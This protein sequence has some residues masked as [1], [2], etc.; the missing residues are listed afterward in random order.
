MTDVKAAVVGTGSNH[1]TAPVPWWWPPRPGALTHLM[2]AVVSGPTTVYVLAQLPVGTGLAVR[3]SVNGSV[4]ATEETT[5]TTAV[6]AW[7]VT[8]CRLNTDAVIV[9]V[10]SGRVADN[11]SVGL[12]EPENEQSQYEPSDPPTFVVVGP[13]EKV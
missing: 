8:V 2:T 9:C 1:V 12:L 7:D 6:P 4:S 13:S 10:I 5:V 3:M 11:V